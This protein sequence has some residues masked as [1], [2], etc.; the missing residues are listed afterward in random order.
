VHFVCSCRILRGLRPEE[1]EDGDDKSNAE[2]VEQTV[3]VSLER[4]IAEGD[5]LE[6]KCQK[7]RVGMQLV[8]AHEL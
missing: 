4:R 1:G 2:L 6:K 8:W 3:N 5:P 7:K